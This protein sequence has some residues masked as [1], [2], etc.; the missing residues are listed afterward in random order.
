MLIRLLEAF[1]WRSQGERFFLARSISHEH[2]SR[3]RRGRGLRIRMW[4]GVGVR[5]LIQG[6]R[7]GMGIEKI[8]RVEGG[9]DFSYVQGK[10]FLP[11]PSQHLSFACY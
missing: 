3:R 2:R 4:T 1:V 11:T 5:E 6:L 7:G 9:L 8:Q 10:S